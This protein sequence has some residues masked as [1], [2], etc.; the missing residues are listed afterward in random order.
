MKLRTK[1]LLIIGISILSLILVF[2]GTVSTLL[3]QNFSQL[4][5]ASVRTSVNRVLEGIDSQLLELE[6]IA[7]DLVQSKKIQSWLIRKNQPKN[8]SE[9]TLNLENLPVNFVGIFDGKGNPLFR[10][11]FNSKNQNI[12]SF[13]PRI[14]SEL[15][16]KNL[17]NLEL[18]LPKSVPD[19]STLPLAKTGIFPSNPPILITIRALPD[20]LEKETWLGF[21]V[22]GY[23]WQ[24]NPPEAWHKFTPL[25]TPFPSIDSPNYPGKLLGNNRHKIPPNFLYLKSLKIWEKPLDKKTISGYAFIPDIQGKDGFLL[26]IDLPRTI[27]QEGQKLLITLTILIVLFG[28]ILGVLTL[29]FL[30]KLVLS[31]LEKLTDSVSHIGDRGNLS[32]RLE[33]I[34]NGQDELASLVESINLMLENLENSQLQGKE[35]EDRY[36]LMAENSTDMISRHH[37]DGVIIYLSPASRILLGYEPSELIGIKPTHLFYGDDLKTVKKAFYTILNLP[38]IYT[39]TYRI[40]RQD[41]H[42]IWLETTTRTIRDLA[43]GSI[44]EIIAVSRDITERKQ[45][46]E[47]LLES[48]YAMRSLYRIT[49]AQNLNF[50]EQLTHL[51]LMGCQQFGLEI[52]VLSKIEGNH[53]QI[54]AVSP[55]N[56]K[57]KKGNIFNLGET[58]CFF[59]I[60]SEESRYFESLRFS[61]FSLPENQYVFEIESYMGIPVMV[62]GKIYGTLAFW[63]SHTLED[64]FKPLDKELLKLMAQWVGGELERQKAAIELAQARDEAL[65]ATHAKSEF[66][67]TMSHEIRT[68]MNA[69]IGMTSLLLDTPLMPDQRDFVE[70]IRNS[71][72]ALLSL[73]NDIL[74]F[75]KIE[76]G[77]MDLEKHPFDLRLCIEEA[78]DLLVT[79][80]NEKNIE[81]VYWIDPQIPLTFIGDITRLRQILVN[82][83]SNAVKFTQEGFVILCC[84]ARK[85]EQF[86][87]EDDYEILLAVKD[88][89]VGIVPERMGRLFKSFSQ[90]DS[91]TTRHYG[92]TGL[93]LAISK[94]LAELMGGTMWVESQGN[95]AGNP[96]EYWQFHGLTKPSQNY[97]TISADH[98]FLS[99]T[100]FY[101]LHNF[102]ELGSVF[103]FTVT[104]SSY[105][106]SSSIN[107]ENSQT[108]LSGKKVLVV[109][110]HPIYQHILVEQLQ[111]WGMSPRGVSSTAEAF[112][113]LTQDQSFDLAIFDLKIP[114][115]NRVTFGEEINNILGDEHRLPLIFVTAIR[116]QELLPELRKNDFI[117]FLNKPIKISNLY[118]AL[119][120]LF[121]KETPEKLNFES[122]NNF[123]IP[124]LSQDNP[125]R[126]LLADD[127][128]VNQKVALQI[129]QKMGYRADVAG[130]GIEVLEA[131]NRQSYDVILM[132]VQMP[133]MDGLEASRRICSQWSVETRPR[134][135]AMTANAMQGDRELCLA[136]GMDDYVTKPIRMEELVRALSQ[137]KYL[138]PSLNISSVN[139]DQKKESEAKE[140]QTQNL[141]FPSSQGTEKDSPL[142]E[143][144]IQGLREIEALEEVIEIYFETAPPLL[145]KIK[146]SLDQESVQDLKNASHSLKSISGTMGARPLFEVCQKLELIA[147][148]SLENNSPL[149]PESLSLFHQIEKEF[150]RVTEALEQEREL[151]SVVS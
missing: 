35:T 94:R 53:Y 115:L 108:F 45:R 17:L 58:F 129:L 18:N 124:I 70:T 113:L 98:P 59:T 15:T 6:M 107:W 117:A 122:K 103:Y 33:K 11:E 148:Q 123:E 28:V 95:L 110:D 69:V 46:E 104:N 120:T 142:D 63:S 71:G 55:T 74:D 37:P 47:E 78:I 131:L 77:K 75:S 66:L 27:D 29:S 147:R 67:A 7:E 82:L 14:N 19:L 127:H 106:Q 21:L 141:L 132:D 87:Q 83:L 93:G 50:E 111:S 51:L 26:K 151:L 139:G 76:S 54:E 24:I 34:G 149:S 126:I 135:I 38:V 79:K 73:I 134:I 31:R 2:Y 56:P 23:Y 102:T 109:D 91:S 101:W 10:Q 80:A 12:S 133:E 99:E 25:L 85:L 114:D 42:Y 16:P 140:S 41:G 92:G 20:P 57:I 118:H 88:T 49:S 22:L 100:F 44:Q 4:E 119:T 65:A 90:I 36:R 43:T 40:R 86:S 143:K 5:S 128:L 96:P 61:G 150:L 39:L 1:T 13:Y 62:R 144:I 138:H 105:S 130:N 68:P 116:R 52:G 137:C 60:M 121:G 32:S 72:D 81:L 112:Q 89:G 136:A 125:L 97:K 3:L 30:E 146:I 48:E 64:P 8:S 84:T 145:E 9:L